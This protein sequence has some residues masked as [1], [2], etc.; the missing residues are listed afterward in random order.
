MKYKFDFGWYLG[1]KNLF[2]VSLPGAQVHTLNFWFWSMTHFT[3]RHRQ[4]KHLIL[5]TVVKNPSLLIYT[6][7]DE[8]IASPLFGFS[9]AAPK[10]TTSILH[11]QQLFSQIDK[12]LLACLQLH[13]EFL[14][15]ITYFYSLPLD[16]L[17]SP[18]LSYFCLTSLR[19]P[20]PPA[21][22][23]PKSRSVSAA[24]HALW[25]ITKSPRCIDAHLDL[26]LPKPRKPSFGGSSI[27]RAIS[28]NAPPSRP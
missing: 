3:K 6:R 13:I 25:K 19:A 24:H 28:L 7:R 4:Y 10:A 8:Q 26:Q 21:G 14:H 20:E 11:A 5:N 2:H 23:S 16:F 1:R 9:R 27:T 15:F 22:A 18:S 17:Y 12:P